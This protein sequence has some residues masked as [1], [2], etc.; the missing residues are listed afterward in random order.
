VTERNEITGSDHAAIAAMEN[1]LFVSAAVGSGKISAPARR[2][3]TN[4]IGLGLHLNGGNILKADAGANLTSPHNSQDRRSFARFW[5]ADSVGGDVAVP[6][7][8]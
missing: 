6:P 3:K 4:S 5:P 8:G 7:T 1:G 2:A